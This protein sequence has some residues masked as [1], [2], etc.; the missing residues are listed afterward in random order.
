MPLLSAGA[1]GDRH[2]IRAA[3]QIRART[4]GV[5]ATFMFDVIH[6]DTG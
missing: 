5:W 4:G 2:H 3:N 6:A 1:F